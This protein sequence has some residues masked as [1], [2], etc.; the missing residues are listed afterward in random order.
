MC[1]LYYEEGGDPDD[2]AQPDP[3]DGTTSTTPLRRLSY[4]RALLLLRTF[5]TLDFGSGQPLYTYLSDRGRRTVE[6]IGQLCVLIVLELFEFEKLV[7]LLEQPEMDEQVRGSM[8]LRGAGGG[9]CA[10]GCED[11]STCM[12]GMLW[13]DASRNMSSCL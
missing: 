6:R 10:G 9:G 8:E 4:D 3:R 7:K 5:S 12:H 1:L 2:I 11:G 13:S